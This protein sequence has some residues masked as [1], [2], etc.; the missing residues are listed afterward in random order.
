M[1]GA[2]SMHATIP[3]H[4]LPA[5]LLELR[6][7]QQRWATVPVGKRVRII[8]RFRQLVAGDAQSLA[9]MV[10]GLVGGSLRRTTAETLVAEVLPLAD[11]CRW[12][13]REAADVLR[14]EYIST[15]SR[16]LWLPKV[17]AMAEREPL[18]VVL[19]VGPGNYPLLLP[20]VQALQA[21]AAGNA[22]LWKPAATGVAAAEAVQYLLREAGLDPD[23]LRVLDPAPATAQQA[24]AAG[25]DKV[26]V[27]GHVD[28]G[29]AVLRQCAETVTPAA[30][31]L[32]G[33]DAVFVLP[34][35]EMERTAQALAFGLR[36]NGSATCMAPRRLFVSE[37]VEAALLPIL[38]RELARLPMTALPQKIGEHARQLLADAAGC[39]AAVLAQGVEGDGRLDSLRYAL[40]LGATPE[41][42]VAESD[43]FAP[44]LAVFRYSNTSAAVEA[45]N[46]CPYAL[47]AAV[48]GAEDQARKLGRSLRA[49]TV[50]VNDLIVTTAD[51]RVSFSGR[52][53]SGFGATR[54]RE[55]LLGMTNVRTTV[56]QRS[57]DRRAYM[58]V[59]EAHTGLFAGFLR[60]AHG[61]GWRARMAGVR[62]MIAAARGLK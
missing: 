19:I 40:V 32:S 33:C 45:H 58:R 60:A 17:S 43:I 26:V 11:A 57:R 35:A 7:A 28:T 3:V 59:T 5:S 12:L 31:E 61:R 54:G 51:P 49:G 52:G 21:L 56:V 41:M 27:T 29:R 38:R 53:R 50:L 8:R 42:Q 6:A 18:G 46:A 44:I 13:E 2:N 47:T 37:Q 4:A 55:G 14:A 25:V 24:I 34:G 20:G 30:A 16:P 36:L 15:R 22:V 1:A 48:F 23:L 10:P 9:A 39:G 62:E